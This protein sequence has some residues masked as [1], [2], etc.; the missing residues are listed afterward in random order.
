MNLVPFVLHSLLTWL[1]RIGAGRRDLFQ[2]Q[3]PL[4]NF[5]IPF[6]QKAVILLSIGC[7]SG[8]SNF[9]MDVTESPF[10]RLKLISLLIQVIL[11]YSIAEYS[12]HI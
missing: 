4:P 9:S 10:L 12:I 6:G 8:F 5:I 1:T 7:V 3:L 2:R 11:E